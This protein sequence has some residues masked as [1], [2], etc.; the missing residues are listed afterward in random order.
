LYQE[1]RENEE[2]LEERTGSLL[3]LPP[4]GKGWSYSQITGR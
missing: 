3:V 1:R 2:L 4:T